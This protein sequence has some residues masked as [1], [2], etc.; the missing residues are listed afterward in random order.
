VAPDHTEI[1][2]HYDRLR[3]SR[4]RLHYAVQPDVVGTANAVLA[5]RAFVSDD[6]FLVLN[7]DNVYPTDVLRALASLDGPGLPAFERATLVNESGF[8]ADRVA[9]F[10][11]IDVDGEG[12]LTRIREKPD[13]HDLAA[14]GPRALISMN[15]WRFDA[16]IFD[17]CRDVP[18]SARG[19]FELPEAVEL[20]LH[21][22]MRLKVI[23]ARGA[24]LDLTRRGD[25]ALVSGR[26]PGPE[27]RL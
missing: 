6:P 15:V 23:R 9:Q 5:A 3:P 27:P 19:E 13:P 2:E 16:R 26:L 4:L 11:V 12:W 20:A 8:P 25:V 18:R 10:A 1:R 24:V 14:R 7:A 22:G 21:R 17:A